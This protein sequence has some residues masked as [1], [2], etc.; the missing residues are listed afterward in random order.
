M[1][2]EAKPRITLVY[3]GCRENERGKPLQHL[4][5]DLTGPPAIDNDGA[6]FKD[7]Q[8]R[9]QVYGSKKKGHSTTN[10]AFAQPGAV[11]SFEKSENGVFGTT[12]HY[13]GRWKCEEDVLKWTAEHNA[14]DRVAELAERAKKENREHLDWEA[15]EPF[16]KAY[17]GRLNYKQQQMLLAQIMQY[18]T[19]HKGDDE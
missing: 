1:T 13:L 15:L 17:N 4:W 6:P 19:K 2:T 11:Y 9:H 16:R 3:I 14:I 12:G 18:I 5:F 10:I 7:D 8:A